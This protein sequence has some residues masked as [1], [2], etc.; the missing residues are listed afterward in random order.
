[1]IGYNVCDEY[2]RFILHQGISELKAVRLED[3]RHETASHE[4]LSKLSACVKSGN[5]SDFRKHKTVYNM[6]SELSLY[7]GVILR[8]DRIVIPAVLQ[9][10][11]LR[12]A[13]ETHLGIV[14]IKQLLQPKFYWFGMDKG[15]ERFVNSCEICAINQPLNLNTPL[16]PVLLPDRPWK[17]G[18]V[19]I[20]SPIENRYIVTYIDYYSSYP[21]A[22]VVSD[23]SANNIVRMLHA[24]FSRFGYPEEI[25]SDNGKQFVSQEFQVFLSSCG[26]KYIRLAPYYPRSNGKVE[27]F[28]RYLKKNVRSDCK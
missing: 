13:H 25:V 11:I 3:F 24:I 20:V 9:E 18:A 2:V 14:K 19:D 27:R 16:Q 5:W 1:M 7:E 17:K 12:L 4:F 6:Q 15:I 28:H 26:I 8:G 22:L 10:R 21:E 23:I